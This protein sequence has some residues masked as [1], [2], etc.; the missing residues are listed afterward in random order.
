MHCRLAHIKILKNFWFA[1]II[2][3][4]LIA[5]VEIRIEKKKVINHKNIFVYNGVLSTYQAQLFIIWWNILNVFYSFYLFICFILFYFIFYFLF[6]LD[7]CFGKQ[8]V[9]QSLISPEEAGLCSN[10][11]RKWIWCHKFYILQWETFF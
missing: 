4:V 10:E 11:K 6:F 9:S 3:S 5:N 2:D 7:D 1:L 8:N